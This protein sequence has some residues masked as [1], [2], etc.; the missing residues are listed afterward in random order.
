M[1]IYLFAVPKAPR[2]AA[3]RQ[4]PRKTIDRGLRAAEA[5]LRGRTRRINAGNSSR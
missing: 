5:I 3:E 1:G 2:V 4:N